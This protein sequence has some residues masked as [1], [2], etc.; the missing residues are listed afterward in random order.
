MIG[1]HYFETLR[2]AEQIKRSC[3]FLTDD[4]APCREC[5]NGCAGYI[6]EPE[7]GRMRVFCWCCHEFGP[8][9]AFRPTA[10]TKAADVSAAH[11]AS[12]TRHPQCS[13]CRQYHASD[14]RHPCE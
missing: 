4:A 13:I 11:R 5:G 12:Q 9:F 3:A 14:D 7:T 6:P 2:R 10:E 8:T 1:T